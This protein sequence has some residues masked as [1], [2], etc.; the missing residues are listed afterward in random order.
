MK[1]P[2]TLVVISP[3]FPEDESATWWVP[4][5]QLM[6]KALQENYPD[7]R[8]TVLSLLYPQH[9][10]SYTWHGI[11]VKAFD[12]M[13]QRKGKRLL[14]WKD[15]W[16]SLK[17]IQHQ[18]HIIGLFSFWN[19][20]CAFISQYFGKMHAIKH[21]S[22]ICGQ[23]AKKENKWVRF[24]RPRSH[25]LAAMGASLRD[26]YHR[27]HGIQPQYLVPN[28]IDQRLFPPALPATRDIDIMAAGSFEPL[29]QYDMY[30]AIIGQ[31]RYTF[32]SLKAIHCGLGREKEKVEGMINS[33]GLQDH[34]TLLGGRPHREVLA[35]MQRSKIFLHTSRSEG[36][37]TVCLEALYAGAHVISFCYPF[38]H[39]V[40][41]WHVVTDAAAMESKAIEI[42]Q[43]AS[44]EYERVLSHSMNDSARTI[45]ELFTQK[46]Q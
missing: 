12:G 31:L 21:I 11:T 24:I 17:K 36:C 30:A 23:D 44:T 33:L 3:A 20:E 32:P 18:C 27:S 25:Q 46:S 2:D 29:K 42:L 26:Q 8:I 10:A 40:P 14:L 16:V 5:Q 22:W 7:I 1:K 34:L 9:Q 15:V 37:S 43:D 38:D 4:S 39:P 35:W 13:H 45:M 28:A 41:H 6:V 19:G